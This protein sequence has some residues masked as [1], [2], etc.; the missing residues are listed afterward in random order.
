MFGLSEALATKSD[1]LPV[2]DATNIFAVRLESK[3]ALTTYFDDMH[4]VCDC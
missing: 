2:Y 3:G 1:W 4:V